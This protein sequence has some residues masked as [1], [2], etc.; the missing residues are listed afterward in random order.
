M[1]PVHRNQLRSNFRLFCHRC[2][3]VRQWGVAYRMIQ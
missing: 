3:G 1:H 2:L